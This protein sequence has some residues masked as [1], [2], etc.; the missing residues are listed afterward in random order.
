MHKKCPDKLF[1]KTDRYYIAYK[2][3]FTNKKDVT[4]IDYKK[5]FTNKKDVTSIDYNRYY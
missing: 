4:S 3:E 2:K 5:E 1:D